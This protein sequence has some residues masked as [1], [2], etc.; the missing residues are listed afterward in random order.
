MGHGYRCA[1]SGR[2]YSFEQANKK[3]LYP[4]QNLQIDQATAVLLLLLLLRL[5][6]T[7]WVTVRLLCHIAG[8]LGHASELLPKEWVGAGL[9]RVQTVQALAGRIDECARCCMLRWN[10]KLSNITKGILA[11]AC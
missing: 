1:N 2:M 7:P 4:V 8:L 10:T 11:L 9:V 6:G 3:R 5:G